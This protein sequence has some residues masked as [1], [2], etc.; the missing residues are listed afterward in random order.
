MAFKRHDYWSRENTM[1]DSTVTG[2]VEIPRLL[3]SWKF[4]R[5]S[6]GNAMFRLVEMPRVV[7]CHESSRGKATARHVETKLSMVTFGPFHAN[8]AWRHAWRRV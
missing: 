8:H 2:L 5:S 4:H 6:R 7:K 3:V 1:R